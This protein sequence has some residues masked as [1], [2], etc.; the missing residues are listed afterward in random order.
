[1]GEIV[2]D[3]VS[4]RFGKIAAVDALDL[5]IDEGEFVS[6][7]GP[8]GC[9]KTTLRVSST[10]CRRRNGTLPWYSRPMRCIRT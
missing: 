8:S 6:I 3:K 7:L 5:V 10:T 4:K 9:G 1:M 2:L